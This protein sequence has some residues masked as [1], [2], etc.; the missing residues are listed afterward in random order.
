MRLSRGIA[1][2]WTDDR[3]G[4]QCAVERRLRPKSR[5]ARE[6]QRDGCCALISG[7][8]QN[9]YLRGRAERRFQMSKCFNHPEGGK[10]SLKGLSS[11]PSTTN[12]QN[13]AR[14]KIHPWKAR[15]GYGI[16]TVASHLAVS[17]G[18]CLRLRGLLSLPLLYCKPSIRR[19]CA[20]SSSVLSIC[21][22]SSRC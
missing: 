15:K 22:S 17:H 21:G 13:L 6:T 2:P 8:G 1:Q 5:F 14:L 7:F 19:L 16:A 20:S 4:G 18:S 10:Q 11:P 3:R 9:P 12:D